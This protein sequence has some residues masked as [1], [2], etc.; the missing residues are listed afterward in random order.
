M[1]PLASVTVD[2]VRFDWRPKRSRWHILDGDVTLCNSPVPEQ[3]RVEHG[4]DAHVV[5]FQGCAICA[6][7]RGRLS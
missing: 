6:R 2:L 5:R 1:T 4:V 3:V 7:C